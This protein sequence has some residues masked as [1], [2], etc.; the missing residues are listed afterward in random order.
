[1]TVKTTIYLPD[2]LKRDIER[3]ARDRNCSEAEV[4]R[5]AIAREVSGGAVSERPLPR[6]GLF[7]GGPGMSEE[8]DELLKGYGE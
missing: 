1:M 4:I 2:E 3:A 8:T 6:F 7:R 5:A